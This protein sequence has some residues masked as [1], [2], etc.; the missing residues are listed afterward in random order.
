MSILLCFSNT[1]LL[2]SCSRNYLAQSIVQS[3]RRESY[4]SIN[5]CVIT[6][7]AH[8]MHRIGSLTSG[9]ILKGFIYESSGYFSGSV[10][11]KVKADHAVPC[12]YCT[13]DAL[14]L[15]GYYKLIINAALIVSLN[16][17]LGRCSFRSL[18]FSHYCI[19]LSQTFPTF[20]SVHSIITS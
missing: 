10:R 4:G 17:S 1:Q 20:I 5:S 7:H 19:S 14:Y 16:T 3:L 8:I 12:F 18:T 6:C 11:P 15:K 2:K 9:E 13:I